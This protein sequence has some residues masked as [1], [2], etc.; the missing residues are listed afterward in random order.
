MIKYKF[1][2][3]TPCYNGENTIKRV[4]DSVESQTYDN[5]E[6]I[7]VNDGST[8]NS[9]TVIRS[10]IERSPT[11]DKIRYYT[12]ENKGK[13][14]TWN[15]AVD[16]STGEVFLPADADDSFIPTT[17]EYFNNRLNEIVTTYGTLE[18]FSGVNV[19]VYDPHTNEIIGSHYP[20]DGLVSDNVELA[21]KYKIRGEHWGCIRTD[22][23]QK[24]KFP[25]VNGHFY[26]ESR[27]W[28]RLA[29][30]G[31][32]V[33]CYNDSLRAY[34]YENTSLTHNKKHAWDFSTNMMHLRFN[35]WTIVNLGW[36]IFRYSP[37]AY[38]K[39]WKQ[40]GVKTVKC[41]LAPIMVLK[42]KTKKF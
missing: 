5:F 35:C 41:A 4:F 38:L 13:H 1:T 32:K 30:L 16:L 14:R 7:I 25:E 22:L 26:T 6:W 19:C 42:V 34:Y 17:L 2:I 20:L 31:Y 28:F 3:F 15:N 23:L 27:L 9:D 10:L 8:D 36:R 21:Y 18:S 33:V 37:V 11:K 12:Q 40:V 39:L 24:N 29:K